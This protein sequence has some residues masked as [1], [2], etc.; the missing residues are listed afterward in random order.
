MR[1]FVKKSTPSKKGIYLQ[2]YQSGYSPER[3]SRNRSYKAIG[4]VNDL[5][6][7]G[8]ADPYA[9]AKNICDEL[10]KTNQLQKEKQIGDAS[11]QKF[12]GHFLIKAMF[13]KLN[14]YDDLNI[15]SSNYKSHYS[16]SSFIRALTY[17]QIIKP[18]SKLDIVKNVLPN[19]YDIEKYSYDQVLDGIEFIGSDYHKYI[20]V[21][22]K[23]IEKLYKRN[24][25]TCYFDCTNYYFEIDYEDNLRKKG[26]SKEERH[27]PI[28]GQALLLDADMIPVDM[29]LYPGNQSEKT[30]LRKRIENL[31]SKHEIKGRIIQVA[32]KGLNCARN[33]YAAV[34]EAKDGYIFSKSVHGRNLNSVEKKWVILEDNNANKWNV[35][36]NYKD[37]VLY[38]Y[39][40]CVDT[41]NYSCKLN[42]ED[43]NEITFAVEEKRVVTYN[44]D[45]ACKQRREIQAEVDRLKAKI[46][47]KQ[48]V[49][50]E[51]GD[52]VKYVNFEAKTKDGKKVKIASSINEEKV[53]EDLLY[54]G[55]NL[56]VT[57]E[58]NAPATEI[59]KA[60]H[61]LW[62]IE[63]SFRLMKTYL[64]AR[65]V[66]VSLKNTIC[67]HF[68]IVYYGL[69]IIRLL[70]LK[71]F[72]DELA[73]EQIFNFI[74]DYKITENYDGT[75][76]NNAT[77]SDTYFKIKEKLGLSKLGNVYLSKKDV[78]SLLKIEI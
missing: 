44:P 74:R 69:V 71:I 22:N 77:A 58:V 36:K 19:I 50:E 2:I 62:R 52:S 26:P 56:L 27:C 45:L 64:E 24:F 40:E 57:S 32:D 66:F 4:Y 17:A 39:K 29:E 51:I 15:V 16:F 55:Y 3:G 30:Y 46:S 5:I 8:I 33:I 37:D 35:V 7:N 60:Y 67:G 59:Y 20:E 63:H 11:T 42:P 53:K 14:M 13:D 72:N 12:L 41:F 1:Y 34:K 73:A 31:K 49:R 25:N 54:A 47:Y 28:V 61:N 38:K 75:Y 48:I 70:E 43:E 18:G 6:N 76:I 65:P 68:L 21:L 9:Y 78:E 23:H 10:N